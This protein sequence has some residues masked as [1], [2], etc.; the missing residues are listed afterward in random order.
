M[1]YRN[2]TLGSRQRIQNVVGSWQR[3][4]TSTL[5]NEFRVGFNK[6]GSSR[7]PPTGVPSMQDLGVRLP[8]YPT[9]PSISE[10]QANGF[11][12]IGDNLF[13]SFP[14]HGIEINDRVNWAKG[15]HQ[16]QFGGE[17]NFQDVKIRNEFRRAG[18]FTFNGGVTGH[19]LSDFLLGQI[20]TF[21]QG[22]GE[23]KDY[24][25]FYASAFFQDDYKVSDRVTLNLGVR[26]EHSPPWYESVGRL[27][28][29]SIDDYNTNV[30]STEFPQ[31]P[32]GETFRGDAGFV[33]DEGVEPSANTASARVG[34]AWDITGDGRTSLRGGGGTFYDQRRDG[35]SGNGGV[36][37][38]PWSLRLNVTRP[39]GPFSDPYRGRTDFDLITDAT[40]GTDRAV[41]PTPVLI[42]TYGDEYKVP[43][44]YNFNLTFE[45]EV[46]TGLMARAGYV[47]SRNRNGRYSLNLNPAIYIPGDTRGPD[48]RRLYAADGIGNIIVQAQDRKSNYDS[49][50]LT[51]SKRYSHGYTITSNY[52][53]SK[54]NGNFG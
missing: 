38:P 45:R 13:A 46:V 36:N 20:N 54:V 12:N 18:H 21:D 11:F 34:F 41:F 49:M 19:A 39:A 3:T 47:G 10:I 2:P 27:M 44:T 1:S 24:E 5:L 17:A 30:R 16:V 42:E 31:A 32:R 37:A 28:H 35:E 4:L 25:V 14:R 33:G 52:T 15:K 23:Y 43:V 48:Q 22:T 26:Y 8:I 7:Y 6:F 40:V 53:L 51:L 29:W 50:Q 9:L